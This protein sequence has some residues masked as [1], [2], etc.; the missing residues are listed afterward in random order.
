[1]YLKMKQYEG[2]CSNVVNLVTSP[3][4]FVFKYFTNELR[5]LPFSTHGIFNTIKK[6]HKTENLWAICPSRLNL[7]KILHANQRYKT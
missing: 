4:K 2:P 3:R 1:M 6:F 5:R 7:C